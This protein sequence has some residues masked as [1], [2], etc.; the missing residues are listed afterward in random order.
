MSRSPSELSLAGDEPAQSSL[1]AATPASDDPARDG[2]LLRLRYKLEDVALSRWFNHLVLVAIVLNCICMAME[3]PVEGSEDRGDQVFLYYMDFVFVG[4]FTVEMAIKLVALGARDYFRDPWNGLDFF[5]VSISYVNIAAAGSGANMKAFLTLRV[6]RGLRPLRTIKRIQGLRILVVS[7]LKSLPMLLNIAIIVFFM[8]VVFSIVGMQLYMGE[9][10]QRCYDVAA[11]AF[12][13][14][15]GVLCLPDDALMLGGR[16][17]PD[18]LVC[19][20]SGQNPSHGLV[21]FDNFLAALLTTFTVISTETWS[22]V[23]YSAQDVSPIG[24]ADVVYF[25]LVVLLGNYLALNLMVAVLK[26]ELS[27]A[28]AIQRMRIMELSMRRHQR[29][30]SLDSP[31]KAK[32][33]E[34]FEADEDASFASI[35]SN[36]KRRPQPCRPLSEGSC[37]PSPSFLSRKLGRHAVALAL[38]KASPNP[39]ERDVP[40]CPSFRLPQGESVDEEVSSPDSSRWGSRAPSLND[41]QRASPT[42]SH[43]VSRGE[44]EQGSRQGSFKQQQSDP[45]C[46]SGTNAAASPPASPPDSPE[47][48]DGRAPPAA[49]P[50][51]GLPKKASFVADLI[52]DA[53]GGTTS[54]LPQDGAHESD[55]LPRSSSP[56][57]ILRTSTDP[58]APASLPAREGGGNFKHGPKAD[59]SDRHCS[60]VPPDRSSVRPPKTQAASGPRAVPAVLDS[61]TRMHPPS[62]ERVT[63]ARGARAAAPTPGTTSGSVSASPSASRSRFFP[64][65]RPPARVLPPTPTKG[66]GPSEDPAGRR[67]RCRPRYW[68]K[69]LVSQGWFEH[70]LLGTVLL[71]TLCLALEYDGMSTQYEGVLKRCNEVFTYIF[72]AELVIKVYALGLKKYVSDRFNVFDAIISILGFVQTMVEASIDLSALRSFKVGRVMRLM[73]LT[74]VARL[75]RFVKYFQRL[76]EIVKIIGHSLAS[77]VYIGLLLLLFMFIFAIL[78]M[79]LFGGK[80]D[81][82]DGQESSVSFDTFLDAVIAVF[83]VLTVEEWNLVMYDGMRAL[84]PAA[85]LFFVLWLVGGVYILLSLFMAVILDS[86]EDKTDVKPGSKAKPRR[87]SKG[88]PKCRSLKSTASSTGGD[89]GESTPRTPRRLLLQS[90]IAKVQLQNAVGNAFKEGAAPSPDATPNKWKLA[91]GK[92]VVANKVTNAFRATTAKSGLTGYSMGCLGPENRLRIEVAKLVRHRYFERFTL[93]AILLNSAA[94]AAEPANLRKG[95]TY[96]LVLFWLDILFTAI[97][98]TEA[99]LKVVAQGL[100]NI[101]G[102]YLQSGA[103]CFDGIVVVTSGVDLAIS[104][105]TSYD[106]GFVKVFRLLRALRPLRMISRLPGMRVVVGSLTRAVPGVITHFCVIV[107]V[108]LVFSIVFPQLFMGKLLQ[109][110]DLDVVHKADC[111]GEFVDPQSGNLTARELEKAYFNFDN[112]PWSFVT[113]FVVSTREGWPKILWNTIDSG[114]F[115]D[116]EEKGWF[117]LFFFYIVAVSFFLINMLTG[118]LYKQFSMIQAEYSAVCRRPGLCGHQWVRNGLWDR[119]FPPPHPATAPEAL[120]PSPAPTQATFLTREQKN[121]VAVQR[122]VLKSRLATLAVEPTSGLRRSVFR[123]VRSN[124]FEVVVMC[125][126]VCNIGLMAAQHSGEPPLFT[127][128]STV[129]NMVFSTLF[130]GEALLKMYGLGRRAYFADGWNRF[131]F[132]IVLGGLIDIGFTLAQIQADGTLTPAQVS[133]EAGADDAIST[134]TQVGRAT[135]VARVAR[136]I[137]VFRVSRMLRL[138]RFLQGVVDLLKAVYLSLPSL[139]NVVSLLFLLLFMYA[140]AAVSLFGLVVRNGVLSEHANFST[141]PIAFITL[142][143]LATGEDWHLFMQACMVTSPECQPEENN[144]GSVAAVPFFITFVFIL[145]WVMLSLFVAVILENF[146][147][148]T[149]PAESDLQKADIKSSHVDAFMRAWQKVSGARSADYLVWERLEELLRELQPPLG[150][151]RGADR[152]AARMVLL[153]LRVKNYDGLVHC[154]EVLLALSERVIGVEVPDDAQS[155]RD[156][157]KLSKAALPTKA[158]NAGGY[159][160][161]YQT[162][163]VMRLQRAWRMKHGLTRVLSATAD[164]RQQ[165]A[166]GDVMMSVLSKWLVDPLDQA[167]RKR[168]SSKLA[169]DTST[170]LPPRRSVTEAGVSQ[171]RSEPRATAVPHDDVKAFAPEA[172]QPEVE[173]EDL[174]E[175][176]VGRDSREAAQEL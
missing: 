7:L 107:T 153:N 131:D 104:S 148:S 66:P 110:N 10:D 45:L 15:D 171:A 76:Q 109:C 128:V 26:T 142:I 105:S 146:S 57:G 156:L 61:P 112:T 176:Q 125:M 60:V 135:R 103:N 155:T 102:A 174:T 55:H 20:R 144:C 35:S 48:E 2:P 88:S 173:V 152:A 161:L 21:H 54:S 127:S 25:V 11:A 166:S 119:G 172:T 28:T 13:E 83:L 114:P 43:A 123:L 36:G 89:S 46:G 164:G 67:V 82:E 170:T 147:K 138:L 98:A 8:L 29:R 1:E 134:A 5:I 84:G 49:A 62:R 18:D 121:W 23:M 58:L 34:S 115:T 143:R 16:G 163:A 85:S 124:A 70:S 32:G 93:T 136:L 158:L 129:C 81:F 96:F 175:F 6:F 139:I 42:P 116:S 106:I 99:L 3:D 97:F 95:S 101:P 130:L 162:V 169:T 31:R 159:D 132:F 150:V 154:R 140:V 91:I 168:R 9:F 51:Q 40:R 73:R 63:G 52:M 151:G 167:A 12:A 41:S 108:M 80:F 59:L 120:T 38:P 56:Q 113:L 17:C 100:L 53:A 64:L 4:L 141:W 160:M 157:R 117:F 118:I 149:R 47:K 71:N 39:S 33:L 69:R 74:R 37:S 137:R 145:S 86:F 30:R 65:P 19:R 92:V 14:P 122:I 87:G 75:G 27:R 165:H 78:G 44:T 22:L 79:Q 72:V 77:L 133:D 50:R 111:V 68:S 94:M 126:I 24:G 90:A